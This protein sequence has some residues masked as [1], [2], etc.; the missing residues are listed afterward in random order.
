M[1]KTTLACALAALGTAAS[2]QDK[3]SLNL[4]CSTE[5]EWCGLMATTFEKD[6]GIKVNMVRKSTGEV[7]AQLNAERANPKTDVWFGGTGDPH[8]QAAEQD[9]TLTYTSPHQP[10][11][12]DWAQSFVKAS[13]GRSAAVYLGPL[14]IAY[15]PEVLARKKLAAPQCWK[16]LAKPEYRGEVQNSNPNSSGTAYTAIATFVQLFGEEPAFELMKSMHRNVSEY[17]RSGAGPVKNAAR[18]ETGVAIGFLALAAGEI[19]QGLP[20]KTLVPCEGTGYEIGAMSLV[21]GARNADNARRFHDWSLTGPAQA[22]AAASGSFTIPSSKDA[23]LHPLM[24]PVAQMK[25]VDYDLK[26]FGSKE[27]RTRLIGRWEREVLS[28]PK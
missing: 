7:L 1:M 17:T 12:H 21:K 11:Q 24:P 2:A 9:L 22:L 26:K 15:N 5:L 18:G 16:D 23:P 10:R 28:A 19:K 8:L 20:L 6:T 25:F 4:L 27:E 14:G 3:G 13:G